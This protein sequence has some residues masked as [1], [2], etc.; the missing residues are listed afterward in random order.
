MQLRAR[1]S[2]QLQKFEFFKIFAV[3]LA[4]NS[5]TQKVS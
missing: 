3:K 2:H 4:P 5:L 1:A